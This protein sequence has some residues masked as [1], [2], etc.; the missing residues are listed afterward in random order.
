MDKKGKVNLK[1][2][3]PDG[4]IEDSY[5][6]SIKLPGLFGIFEVLPGHENYISLLAQGVISIKSQGK[7]L[8]Y[9]IIS[10]SFFQFKNHTNMCEIS[11]E[12]ARLSE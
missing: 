2:V 12:Y 10:K 3:I 8:P 1:I 7:F 5:H 6:D 4:I 11:S 9:Y